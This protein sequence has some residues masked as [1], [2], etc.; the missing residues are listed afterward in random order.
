MNKEYCQKDPRE[1]AMKM[2]K[3]KKRENAMKHFWE[4]RVQETIY[5]TIQQVVFPVSSSRPA[6]AATLSGSPRQD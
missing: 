2:P 6:L 3:E 5:M 4:M 1:N